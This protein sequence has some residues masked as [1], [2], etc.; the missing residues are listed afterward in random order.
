ISAVVAN[1]MQ[2]RWPIGPFVA[3]AMALGILW[4]R[5]NKTILP[6]RGFSL[7][8]LTWPG[9]LAGA[10]AL[11]LWLATPSGARLLILNR[12]LRWS[13]PAVAAAVAIPA[14]IRRRGDPITAYGLLCFVSLAGAVTHNLSGASFR[15][16]YD[17]N[18]LIVLAL[19]ALFALAAAA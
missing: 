14:I 17:N 2:Y 19:G 1:L 5:Q 13:S 3:S 9:T 6:D 16:F 7:P 15:L 8:H 10:V 11:A 4:R 12:G 18:P